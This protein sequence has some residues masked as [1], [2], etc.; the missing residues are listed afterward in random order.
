ML[1]RPPR[2]ILGPLKLFERCIRFHGAL[3]VAGSLSEASNRWP[4]ERP[5]CLPAWRACQAT[6]HGADYHL[7]DSMGDGVYGGGGDDDD[8]VDDDD[9]DDYDDDDDVLTLVR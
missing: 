7:F 5:L 1:I 4:L 6:R 3:E 9:D 2:L 8:D